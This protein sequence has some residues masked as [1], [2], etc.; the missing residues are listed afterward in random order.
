MSQKT[1]FF[2]LFRSAYKRHTSFNMPC[3]PILSL[4]FANQLYSF[5][6]ILNSLLL[7]IN[8]VS[9]T[10]VKDKV[11]FFPLKLLH[12]FSAVF[13]MPLLSQY[14]FHITRSAA[15]S[16]SLPHSTILGIPHVRSVTIDQKVA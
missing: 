2:M 1:I 12:P 9:V 3:I 5:I 15:Y 10:G 14:T 6:L 13:K 4:E 8:S 11:L 16:G 7:V